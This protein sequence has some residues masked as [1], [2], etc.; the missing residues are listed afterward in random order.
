MD[1]VRREYIN[2]FLLKSIIWGVKWAY[3]GIPDPTHTT[4]TKFKTPEH[5]CE[6]LTT[7]LINAWHWITGQTLLILCRGVKRGGVGGWTGSR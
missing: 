3:I 6:V 1:S 2:D 4:P 5:F 7:Y